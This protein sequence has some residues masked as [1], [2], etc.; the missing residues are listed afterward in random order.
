[1]PWKVDFLG[2]PGMCCC[3]LFGSVLTLDDFNGA[4]LS[5]LHTSGYG[6]WVKTLGTILGDGIAIVVFSKG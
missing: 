4:L 1:M 5:C 2:R 6:P 3:S